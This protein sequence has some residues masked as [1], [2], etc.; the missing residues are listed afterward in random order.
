MTTAMEI[1]PA[2][3]ARDEQ[4]IRAVRLA[5][6][7]R[8]QGIS[9]AID[10]DDADAACRHVLAWIGGRAVATGR[11]A[12]DGHIGRIAVLRDWRRQGLGRAV[13][14]ALVDLAARDGL[15][16]VYLHAQLSARDFYL[17]LGFHEAGPPF[18]EAGI[19]HVNMTRDLDLNR[20]Q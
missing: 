20:R 19:P 11:M 18:E 5:V 3:W 8:E 13:V 17:K 14:G 4:A 16:A 7:V 6:F 2:S 1:R 10:F 12:A 15:A 9:E